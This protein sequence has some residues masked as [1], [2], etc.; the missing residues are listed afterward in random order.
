MKCIIYKRLW[1]P[2]VAPA[3]TA[4]PT[5]IC[6][7]AL[8]DQ[9]LL[10][11]TDRNTPQQPN[12]YL[13][14]LSPIKMCIFFRQLPKVGVRLCTDETHGRRNYDVVNTIS[15]LA[16]SC[17]TASIRQT[18]SF[19]SYKPLNQINYISEFANSL[20]HQIWVNAIF[21]YQLTVDSNH[22]YVHIWLISPI[23]NTH[24]FPHHGPLCFTTRVLNQLRKAEQQQRRAAL[25]MMCVSV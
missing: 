10:P 25:S 22:T 16:R 21:N 6:L 4:T 11:E 2:L 13:Y 23:G 8:S 1:F 5:H 3:S 18:Q 24:C 12:S 7:Y 14:Y 9:N 19:R 15:M 20:A 17:S